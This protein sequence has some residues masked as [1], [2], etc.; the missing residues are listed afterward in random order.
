ML[1]AFA[2]MYMFFSVSMSISDTPDNKACQLF[3]T[4]AVTQSREAVQNK[5]KPQ[6]INPVIVDYIEELKK[7][8]YYKNDFSD[9]DLN[10]RHAILR[11]QS[12]INM[13]VTGLWD[14]ECLLALKRRLGDGTM[15]Y[16]DIVENPPAENNWI[17]INKSK[18]ILTLYE[19]KKVVGKYPVA[20]GTSSTPTPSGKFQIAVK[21][22]DPVWGGGGYAKPVAGGIPENPLGYRWMGLSINGGGDYGIHGNNSP[23]SI[24]TYASHGCIRMINSDV[25]YLYKIVP[26]NTPVWIGEDSELNK[27][28]IKQPIYPSN[29]NGS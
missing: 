8:G 9:N 22:V 15:N 5:L 28:G 20:V 2:V 19:G 4:E 17:A 27:W 16:T 6:Q 14:S 25:E 21:V 11:F 12:D 18:R 26:V 29:Q 23:Y 10:L 1:E 13:S 24:G 7:M 3:T